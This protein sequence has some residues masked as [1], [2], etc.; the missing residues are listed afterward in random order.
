MHNPIFLKGV[1]IFC[2]KM[3]L[4]FKKPSI[5]FFNKHLKI[6][7]FTHTYLT[8]LI[9]QPEP[10]EGLKIRGASNMVSIIFPLVR[11][12]LIDLPK[13]GGG[14]CPPAHL[15]PQVLSYT[16][17]NFYV[18]QLYMNMWN[19]VTDITP[20]FF[21]FCGIL[22]LTVETCSVYDCISL[23]I[24]R[25]HFPIETEAISLGHHGG[26][27]GHLGQQCTSIASFNF[28]LKNFQQHVSR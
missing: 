16:S 21:H 22:L 17:Y 24:S 14:K 9:M 28:V 26:Y 15:V 19:L 10:A 25:H 12:G 6:F 23:Q 2:I 11:I 5:S 3:S 13:Y 27:S 4:D 7:P 18:Q 1:L 8:K 20:S